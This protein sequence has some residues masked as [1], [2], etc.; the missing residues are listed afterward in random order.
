MTD[1][2]VLVEKTSTDSAV[3]NN[4]SIVLVATNLLQSVVTT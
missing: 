3:L 2:Y 1:E 4:E